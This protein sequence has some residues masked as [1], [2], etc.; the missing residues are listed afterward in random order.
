MLESLPDADVQLEMAEGESAARSV[1]HE[2]IEY[3]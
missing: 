3:G 2:W 1:R